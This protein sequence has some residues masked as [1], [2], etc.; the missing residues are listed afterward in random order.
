MDECS[1]PWGKYEILLSE[2]NCKVKKISVNP[3][4]AL[5]YQYHLKRAEDW[6]IVQGHGIVTIDE[7]VFNVGPGSSIHIPLL[8]KHRMKNTSDCE[9]VFIEVQTGEYFGEDDIVRI[10]DNYGRV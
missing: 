6:V 4:A 2:K 9:L 1:R 3:G 8:S 10:E 5:S 7:D